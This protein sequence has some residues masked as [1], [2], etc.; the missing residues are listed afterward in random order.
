MAPR[1]LAILGGSGLYA[2][3][4]L[5]LDTSKRT[6]DDCVHDITTAIEACAG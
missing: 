6:I 1:T 4:D 5:V 3:A 2:M